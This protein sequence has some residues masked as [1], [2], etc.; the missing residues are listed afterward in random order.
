MLKHEYLENP[1]RAASIPYWKTACIAIPDNTKIVHDSEFDTEL[2]KRYQDEPYFRL[3]HPMLEVEPVSLPEGYSLQEASVP[4]F[5][6]HINSCYDDIGI[7]VPEMQRNML[8]EQYSSELWLAVKE[9]CRG[10]IVA[11]GIAE[12]DREI[13]EGVLEWI[14]VSK[15][16]RRCGL[17]SYL[18]SELLWRMRKA[19]KFVTVS[20]KCNNPDYPEGLYRKC[21]FCGNDVWHILREREQTAFA[22]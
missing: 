17:G 2:L 10:K 7:T 16:Y 14:Q 13:G 15:D 22:E 11:T 19:A 4:D 8:R 18:V 9:D 21:G 3:R 1:C 20:G 6:E 5:V 12:L